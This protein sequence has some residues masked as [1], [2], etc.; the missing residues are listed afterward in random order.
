MRSVNGTIFR[1]V[2][3]LFAAAVFLIS[4]AVF[5]A[6][7]AAA[8]E[9]PSTEKLKAAYVYCLDTGD[10]EG[11]ELFS[12]GVEEEIYPA[13]STKIMTAFVALDE[14]SGRLDERVTLTHEMLS[15]VIGSRLGLEEGE[16]LSIRDL[17][18]I[19]VTGGNNDAAYCLAHLSANSSVAEF[20]DKMN[21]KAFEITGSTKTHYTNPSG[22]HD[23][24][25]KTTGYDTFLIAKYAW[26]NYE[27]FRDAASAQMYPLA[28]TNKREFVNVYNKNCF[29]SSYY[30]D[31]Y[32]ATGYF[33][34][35]YC[36]IN[37][38]G[39]N[40]GGQCLITVYKTEELSFLVLVMGAEW[41]DDA[42]YSYVN[43]KALAEWASA[44]F[45]RREVLT[46]D[47]VVC[48]LPVSLA[49]SMDHI[50]V[51]PER[52]ISVFLPTDVDIDHEIEFVWSTDE[53]LTAPLHAGD[54]VGT[55]TAYY[56]GQPLDNGTCSL[57]V[58]ADVE[59]SEFLF[60][61]KRIENFTTSRGFIAAVIFA[62]VASV[63]FVFFN[64]RRRKVSKM[65]VGTVSTVRRRTKR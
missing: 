58:T 53:D 41:D 17:F 44:S 18:Y 56:G 35:S 63:A 50:T 42:N 20:V 61:L 6:P 62:I 59:R 37:A 3:S 23:D 9:D 40:E 26:E 12:R 51:S 4:F 5:A 10:G 25:M 27:L 57:I 19:L 38:G 15:D 8:V 16:E 48:D 7:R 31:T 49:I 65:S 14:L 47:Q 29:I 60:A 54:P 45:A 21:A 43:A 1:R 33:D 2:L 28:A 13:S 55:I 52:A 32:D 30:A 24:L 46:T 22:I 39:T 36:G 11:R 34:G 64:A